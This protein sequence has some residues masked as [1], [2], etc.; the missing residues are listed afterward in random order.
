MKLKRSC[1]LNFR[2]GGGRTD[3]PP[4]G[5]LVQPHSEKADVRQEGIGARLLVSRNFAGKS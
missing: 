1:S 3:G 4:D 5:R 2:R